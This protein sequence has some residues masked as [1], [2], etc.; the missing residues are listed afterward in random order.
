[1]IDEELNATTSARNFEQE[2]ADSIKSGYTEE[3]TKEL[4]A[5]YHDNDVARALPL[6]T[7]AE[8]RLLYSALGI[9]RLSDVFTYLDDPEPYIEEVGSDKAADIVESMDSDDAADVLGELDEDKKQDIIRLMDEESARDLK[10]LEHYD[11]DSVGS[12]M[13]ND[14]VAVEKSCGVKEAMKSIIDEA[15]EKDNVSTVFVTDGGVYCGAFKLKDLV[16][17]R[18]ATPLDDIVTT[19]FPFLYA[20]DKIA[21]VL[22]DLK[23]YS[24][25]CLPVLDNDNRLIGALTSADVVEAVDEEMS[26]DYAKLAGLSAGDDQEDGI[27][28]NMLKR[29]PWLIVLLL[30]DLFIG[31]YTG[32]FEAAIVGLPFLV[33]FQQMISG[34]SGNVGTQS[35]AVSVRVLSQG[36][37]GKKMR[38][39]VFK[40]F[41]VGFLNGLVTGVLSAIAVCVFC[42]FTKST[43]E[44]F[45]S[46]M[47]AG[48]AVGT[49]M[50]ASATVS[51]LTG[52]LVPIFFYKVKI[53]PAVA[54][55]PLI[56]TINDLAAITVYYGLAMLFFMNLL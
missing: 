53:D 5:D 10:L 38:K 9:D 1:M 42:F 28:K 33:C 11:E 46:A 13:T 49:A 30:L 41:S 47:T 16:I 43:G 12:R 22:S 39:L 20:D 44:N 17:A 4:L 7:K 32:I 25:A 8:R 54:S 14:F 56:T 36:A 6:L 21:D 34:M 40:E 50:L 29:L 55:G 31:A 2:I 23:G 19:S 51:S 37:D 45:S 3:R 15:A 18:S 48:L 35:L 27:G 26:D 24:E 52:T